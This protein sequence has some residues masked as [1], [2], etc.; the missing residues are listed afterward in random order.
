MQVVPAISY[1]LT[2]NLSAGIGLTATRAELTANRYIIGFPGKSG[3]FPKDLATRE[4][5]GGGFEAGVFYM[6]DYGW[7]LGV[8]YKSRQWMEPIEYSEPGADVAFRFDYPSITSVGISYSGFE[9]WIIACDV[10]Y[11]DYASTTGFASGG[12]DSSGKLNGLEWNN[13]FA[14]ALGVQRQIGEQFSVRMGYSYNDNPITD[15]DV[16]LLN[17]AQPLITQHAIYTG[18]SFTFADNWIVSVAYAHGFANTISG[19]IT[20]P[21]LTPLTDNQGNPVA[22]TRVASGVSLDMLSVGCTKRF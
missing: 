8:S 5:W 12:F 19:P 16:V 13:I 4:F 1:Q 3:M 17:V 10:R 7:G 18:A 22:N 15:P 14:V 11:F 20:K 9:Q 6:T 2:P 21:N